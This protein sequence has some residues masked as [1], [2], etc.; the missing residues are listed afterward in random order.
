MTRP[1]ADIV[2]RPTPAAWPV[3]AALALFAAGI[4]LDGLLVKL[5]GSASIALG[6]PLVLV[7]FWRLVECGRLRS[8]PAALLF[9]VAFAAWTAASVVWAT[10][11]VE[12]V[13]RIVTVGQLLAFVWL[14]WQV[15]RSRSELRWLLFGFVA[16]CSV[17]AIEAWR[18]LSR[19]EAVQ[20]G[21]VRYAV[22]GFDVNDI[23]VTLAVGIPMTTYLAFAG[24]R[25]A[26]YLA[27]LYLPLAGG[28][29][30]LSGSRGAA[31]SAAAALVAVALW[32]ARASRQALTWTVA[33]LVLAGVVS[34][35]LVPA[36]TWAR[37]FTLR[38]QVASG[39]MA[40]RAQ[41]WGAGLR[42]L[43]RHP[44]VGVG[45][46]GFSRAVLPMLGTTLVAHN[47]LLSVAVELGLVGLGMFAAPFLLVLRGVGRSALHERALAW[48]LML[49]WLVGASSLT[50]EFR[51][52]TWF[53][54]LVGAALGA[55]RTPAEASAPE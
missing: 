23:G 48:S 30:A 13:K 19:G 3:R 53:V 18:A 52:T 14:A 2:E 25:R 44:I 41:I 9:L 29:I 16:G 47:T 8:A 55:I 7:A 27:L 37:I 31:L 54:L 38:E 22:S 1:E 42:V 40:D 35:V 26:A 20:E 28:A 50:W 4:P 51:K 36:E 39:S 6:A 43:A 10:D 32:A 17:A 24:R 45:A 33:L 21:S 11:Q 12:L 34:Q 46:G 15:I 49:V 5:L